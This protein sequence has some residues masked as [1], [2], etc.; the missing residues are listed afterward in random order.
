[1]V[2][3]GIVLGHKISGDAIEIDKAKLDTIEKLP[4]PTSAKD[5]QS[6]LGWE[7]LEHNHSGTVG[8]H[9][10]VNRTTEKILEAALAL[11]TN[12]ARVV[13]KFLKKLF[14]WFGTPRAIINDMGT[15][16]C[17]TQFEKVMKKY[18]VEVKNCELKRILEKTIHHNWCDW[19]ERLDDVLWAYRTSYKTST[20]HTP[21]LLVYGK[22]CHLSAELEHQAYW[23]IKLLNLDM[24]N[25]QKKW[26]YQLNELEEHRLN[27]YE[28]TLLYKEKMRR[29]HDDH[30]RKEK[31]FQVAKQVL[32]FNS[33]LKL[34]PG[35]L[36]SH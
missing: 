23:V 22:A 29:I 11:P 20:G 16:F 26:K 34:F 13:V 9:F 28:N 3:E 4:S 27:A 36:M 5:V 6:F 35:K 24:K 7:I 15:P 10:S 18:G 2:I 1:M 19:L 33:R 25:V 14:S 21:Y 8:G 17:N 31:Q 30:L 12:D 32:L